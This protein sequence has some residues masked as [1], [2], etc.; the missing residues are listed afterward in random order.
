ML[1]RQGD[2]RNFS[3]SLYLFR[4]FVREWV[5]VTLILLPL[6][7][8]LSLGRL[9]SLDNMIYDRL[10]PHLPVAVEPNI[11]LVEI[12]ERSVEALGRWPWPRE[13]HARLLERLSEARPAAILLDV[14]F[15]E[16]TPDP[17]Q[18]RRLGEAL[19][20]AGNVSLPLLRQSVARPGEALGVVL[21]VPVI[22]S[23][24]QQIGHINVAV[25]FDGVMRH[26]YL[27]EGLRGEP[28]LQLAWLLYQQ[29]MMAAGEPAQLPGRPDKR[30]DEGWQRDHLIRIPFASRFPSVSYVSVLRGEVPDE[31]LRDRVLL[32]GATA[33][34]LG[35]RYATPISP[36]SGLIPGVVV[37][38]DILNG[39]LAQQSIV[40]LSSGVAALLAMVPVVLLLLSLL[41]TRLR[42]AVELALVM[43]A[44]TLLLCWMLLQWGWW[45][46]PAASL[47]GLLLATL[48]WNWRRLSAVLAYF[49]WELTRLEA[50]PKVLP[51]HSLPPRKVL[52]DR[53]QQRLMT[54]ER[55]VGRVKDT[56]RFISDGLE[57]LPVATLVCTMDERILMANLLARQLAGRELVGSDVST[58]LRSLGYRVAETKT[59]RIEELNGVE[60]RTTN[61][62]SLRLD[63]SSI[64]PGAGVIQPC[65][66]IGLTDL[67]AEREAEAQRSNMLRFLSHDLRAPHIAIQS[68]LESAERERG[69]QE[70]YEQISFQTNRALRL[71]DDFTQLSRAESPAF[72]LEPVLFASVALDA[73]DQVWALARAKDI[74]LDKDLDED[75][76]VMADAA[77]LCRA[78]F[79]LLENAIKYSPPGKRVKISLAREREWAVCSVTDQG[80]GIDSEDIPNLFDLYRR[81]STSRTSDG[82]GLG[83]P[84]VGMVAGCHGGY[85]E[86]FSELGK[87]SQ[88]RLCLPLCADA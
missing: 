58:Y 65:L 86:C 62:R 3:M 44:A 5:L 25:D 38:A 88:F 72:R 73:C 70:T 15:T 63:V 34:G 55:A 35:D 18:D 8:L 22:A 69:R 67:T 7:A 39:L 11:L 20:K 85:V 77:L 45:W 29:L 24:A 82:L 41:L 4:R 32:V 19:C 83:L 75:L 68:L 74:P 16:P 26:V 71:I 78:V 12:D 9:V 27:R 21:P 50:E 48:L 80:E 76:M 42:F 57:H 87:G 31:L 47:L 49:G 53:L 1:R 52:G 36:Y 43:A 64:Q 2:N 51:E 10:L 37:Q 13:I 33:L 61:G 40:P 60:F 54:L 28:R 59:V 46:P 66:L 6:T 30:T 14:L 79:N 56:R 81:F 23:C 17:E 84:M